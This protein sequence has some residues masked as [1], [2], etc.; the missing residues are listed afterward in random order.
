MYSFENL[1]KC[2]DALLSDKT[3]E[4]IIVRVGRG[5]EIFCDVKKTS[6]D[7]VLTEETLFDMA[8]VTKIVVTTS[9]ALMAIDKGLLSV[10]DPVSKFFP[11]P[12][13]KKEMTVKNLMTHTMGIGHKS[14]LKHT[15]GYESV[16]NYILNIPSDIP[17]GTGIRYSC[18]G[19]ILLGRILET[20]YGERL[21]KAFRKYVA[22]PLGMNMTTFLPDKTLDIVNANKTEEMRGIVN[23][24]NCRYLGCVAGN[25]GLFSNL[26]D[27]TTFAKML[28][29]R[30]APLFSKETFL[31]AAKNYTADMETT[32]THGHRGL[33]YIHVNE[34][35]GQVAGLFPDGSVGHCGHT[36]QSVFVD[37]ESGLYVIVLSDATRSIAKKLGKSSYEPVM[38]MRRELHSAIKADLGLSAE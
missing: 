37:P 11:V 4:N 36:G 22:E 33:G 8:S 29:A 10:S 15:G 31:L 30:G 26:E 7:R 20:I 27:M 2:V 38:Q 32:D 6:Q 9:L 16:E 21:D 18:P 28:I 24:Y 12:D 34:H 13:D 23:D 19:F 14:L 5:D 17:I 3:V 35:F 25:A 1:E